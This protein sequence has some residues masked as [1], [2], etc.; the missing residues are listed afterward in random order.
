MITMDYGSLYTAVTNY[1]INP[2]SCSLAVLS[3]T[4]VNYKFHDQI[5]FFP[6]A[7]S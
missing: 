1:A 6:S 2:E 7:G 4:Y 5:K 3:F